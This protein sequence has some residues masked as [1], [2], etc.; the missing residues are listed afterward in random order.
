MLKQSLPTLM[1]AVFAGV[2]AAAGVAAAQDAQPP[3]SAAAGQ[4][5]PGQAAGQ[6]PQA[7]ITTTPCG[8]PLA[9]PA[10]LLRAS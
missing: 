8:S 10:A 3:A 9:M 2:L 4:A 5:A 6:D 7:A 1:A